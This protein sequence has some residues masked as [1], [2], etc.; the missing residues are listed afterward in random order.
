MN[1]PKIVEDHAKFE[2]EPNVYIPVDYVSAGNDTIELES[3][4]IVE[5][6]WKELWPPT[7]EFL[8]QMRRQND[9]SADIA[10]SGMRVKLLGVDEI[11]GPDTDWEVSF[12]IIADGYSEWGVAFSGWKIDPDMSQPYF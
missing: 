10:P 5:S 9:F 11:I 4:Q 6:K 8:K 1:E 3:L 7:L 12:T 2:C